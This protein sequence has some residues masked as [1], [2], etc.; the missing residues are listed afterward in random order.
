MPRLA[1]AL[2]RYSKA[3]LAAKLEAIGLPFAPI[4]KPWDLLDDPHLKD[5]GGLLETRTAGRARRST[6]LRCRS[7]STA[8]GCPSAATR[9]R[10]AKARASCC[11]GSGTAA[12][13]IDGLRASGTIALP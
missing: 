6:R 9:R 8:S 12:A 10:S 2:K 3:D 5:S 13:H 4:S 7:R 1:E 11:R